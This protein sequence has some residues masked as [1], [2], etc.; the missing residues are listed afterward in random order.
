VGQVPQAMSEALKDYGYEAEG[1]SGETFAGLAR[2][3]YR[4]RPSVVHARNNH[5]KAAAV[6]KLMGIPL[7]IHAGR[8]DTGS[9]TARAA[10]MA[11]RTVCAGAAVREAILEYGA[12]AS[13]TVVMRSLVESGAPEAPSAMLDPHVRWVVAAS[14]CDGPDRGHQDLLLAFSSV[15]RTRPKVKLFIAGDG[16][17]A[18]KLRAQADLA[19][20]RNRVVVHA[21]PACQLPSVFAK[22]AVVVGPSRAGNSPDA[23]PEAL[24]IGAAVIATGV[25]SHPVWIREGRTGF[26]VPPRSPASMGIRLA[27]LLDDPDLARRVGGAAHRAS[28][29]A[30]QPRAV[31]Q[32][33]ARCYAV[34]ARTSVAASR[35]SLYLPDPTLSRA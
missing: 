10:R 21:V 32:E 18:H 11:E 34:I 31:A 2:E 28:V 9:G 4:V 20:L 14:P 12:P 15:A 6:S 27:Q 23:V 33:L 3:L 8:D 30:S 35:V 19:G 29:E 1:V 13:S 17:E 5:L 25:G 16:C 7:L 22:A 26:L 24:A